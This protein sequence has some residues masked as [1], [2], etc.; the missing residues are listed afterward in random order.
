MFEEESA[1]QV[2]SP[3]A[4]EMYPQGNILVSILETS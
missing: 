4:E 2:T 3:R 1:H